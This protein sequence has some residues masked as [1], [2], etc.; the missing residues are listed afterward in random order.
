MNADVDLSC[1][2]FYLPPYIPLGMS[3]HKAI[4]HNRELISWTVGKTITP[5]DTHVV[6]KDD[7]GVRK[8]S[9]SEFRFIIKEDPISRMIRKK[10]A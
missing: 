1:V 8:I 5:P 6:Y 3:L 4:K 7:P 2:D 10:S 9:I